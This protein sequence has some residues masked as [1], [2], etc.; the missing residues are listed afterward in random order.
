MAVDWNKLRNIASGVPVRDP[1]VLTAQ[2]TGTV[3]SG[4]TTT[5]DVI[6][7]NRTRIDEIETALV[8]LGLLEESGTA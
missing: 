5:D 8:D 6:E 3:N 1:M 4:D 7:N 2:D